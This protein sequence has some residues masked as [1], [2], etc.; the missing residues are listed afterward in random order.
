MT[1]RRGSSRGAASLAHAE[2]R[3]VRAE[4]GALALLVAALL[5]C[6][7]AEEESGGGK[8]GGG[9]AGGLAAQCTQDALAGQCPPGSHPFV[10]AGPTS[11]C[12]TGSGDIVA[13]DGT[14]LGI[15]KGTNDCIVE[16]NFV[17]P[18]RCGVD[19][20]TTEGVF[21]RSCADAAA[22][23]NGICEGG[24]GPEVCPEDCSE[25]CTLGER[26]CFG[27]DV[28]ECD[29]VGNWETIA[30]R[31]DQRCELHAFDGAVCQTRVSPSGGTFPGTGS[32]G[33]SS[34]ACAGVVNPELDL[35][36]CSAADC[37]SLRLAA[38]ADGET[39][40]VLVSSDLVVATLGGSDVVHD[41]PLTGAVALSDCNG[42]S[43]CRLIS[44]AREPVIVDVATGTY[45]PG[46]RV[47]DDV[48]PVVL[49]AASITLDGSVGAVG[50]AVGRAPLVAFWNL[51]TAALVRLVRFADPTVPN[52]GAPTALAFSVDG[53]V[54]AEGRDDGVVVVW[55]VA[56]ARYSTIL[57][58]GA[59]AVRSLAWSPAGDDRLLVAGSRLELWDVAA[60][61]QLWTAGSSNG[62]HVA[63]CP[64]G[65]L[66]AVSRSGFGADTELRDR[67]G[68][69]VGTLP[70]GGPLHFARDGGRLMVGRRIYGP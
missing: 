45:R 34:A 38:F 6:G 14:V 52:E 46:E 15:C 25:D 68:A 35:V 36:P 47:V 22:C 58:T 48:T 19:R 40:G 8:G 11:R 18:C 30:C 12:G 44:A 27:D 64:D 60:K 66:F 53:G 57:K 39:G 37:G 4:A 50:M 23:G 67:A 21:C 51:E 20:I 2:L 24:E 61:A 62:A 69:L 32:L 13:P 54:L 1:R 5:A 33:V 55:N 49:G 31:P 63:P 17:N 7:A 59:G 43:G 16:C 9:G 10:S 56:E 70:Q 28:E 29:D 26:R 42:G 41:L 65:S 3:G